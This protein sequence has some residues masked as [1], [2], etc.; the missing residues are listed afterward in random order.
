MNY[1]FG[2]VI[3]IQFALL[4][5]ALRWRIDRKEKHLPFSSPTPQNGKSSRHNYQPTQG[6]QYQ[7]R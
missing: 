3:V 1:F 7:E 4:F 5:F 2:I 6:N